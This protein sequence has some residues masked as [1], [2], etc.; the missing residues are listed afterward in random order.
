MFYI[1]NLPKHKKVQLQ[2]NTALF[3]IWGGDKHFPA[4]FL[5]LQ[6][7]QTTHSTPIIN[8][9]IVI[10]DNTVNNHHE[11]FISLIYLKKCSAVR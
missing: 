11:C 8:P 6:S 10:P 4:N 9:V 2:K 3:I 1:S 5:N 7:F